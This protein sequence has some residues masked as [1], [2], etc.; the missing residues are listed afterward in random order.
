MSTENFKNILETADDRTRARW[1]AVADKIG[2]EARAVL[3]VTLTAEEIMALPSARLAVLTD[4]SLSASWMEEAQALGPV[5]EA[6]R[7]AA[8]AEKIAAG[9]EEEH[10]A[11]ARL[12]PAQRI[13]RSRELGMTGAETKDSSSV[14]DEATM[15]RRVLA[16]SPAQRIAKARQWGLIS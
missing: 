11:L 14:T 3:G 10:A 16:L 15:L 2:T 7:N 8:V 13:S 1:E 12:S 9:D 5:R 4:D 6:A